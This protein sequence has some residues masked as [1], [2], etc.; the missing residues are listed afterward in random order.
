MSEKFIY[1]ID[2]YNMPQFWINF[3]QHTPPSKPVSIHSLTDY[4]NGLLKPYNAVY[5]QED[6]LY[7]QF[8]TEQD[9]MF[10]LLKWS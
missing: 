4:I 9:Y 10:F 7:I 1:T 3:L 6:K 2:S 5:F 8:E